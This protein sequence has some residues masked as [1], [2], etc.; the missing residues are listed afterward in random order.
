MN[1]DQ[2]TKESVTRIDAE[3][4]AARTTST[5]GLAELQLLWSATERERM[6]VEFDAAGCVVRANANFLSLM[7][8]GMTEIRGEHDRMFCDEAYAASGAYISL[9][10]NLSAGKPQAGEY[11]RLARGGREVWIHGSY[12]PILDNSGAL[13]KVIKTATDITAQKHYADDA[14]GKLRA[15]ERS[16][17]RVEFDLRGNVLDA[18]ENFLALL[19]YTLDEIR[20]QHHRMFCEP[21]YASTSEYQSFWDKL[22]RGEYDSGQYKRIGKG[23][24]EIWIQAAYNPVIST[25]GRLLKIVKFAA[26]IS[27]ERR[28]A[29]DNQGRLNAIDRANGI[30]EFDLEGNVLTANQNF[31]DATGYTL[32]EIV[33]KHHKIFCQPEFVASAEYRDFWSKLGRGEFY[34]GRYL[35]LSKHGY[36]VW[37]QASYN[38]IFDSNGKPFK[39]IKFAMDISTEVERERRIQSHLLAMS[40]KINELSLSITG[41]AQS[42]RQATEVAN[43]TQQEAESG[44]NTLGQSIEAIRAIEKSSAGINEIVKVIS[45]IANQ[46]NMLAFNAAIEAARAGEHGLGFSVVAS[47]V[48]KLAERS[49]QATREISKL[50]DE[51]VQRV[52]LGSRTSA[53]ASDG[54]ERIRAGVER[55]T[56][57]IGAIHEVTQQQA[58]ATHAVA[59]LLHELTLVT[60]G[61]VA[62]KHGSAGMTVVTADAA[63]SA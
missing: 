13:V 57:T 45:D 23:G 17:A 27:G 6:V 41:I 29:A 3:A 25:D 61:D 24:R 26:D 18:N 40:E 2:S 15:M 9:W 35:R 1:A 53:R 42:T 59:H 52:D 43:E 4:A 30:V 20:G 7:G 38:P 39:V 37:L 51:S 34:S 47:E 54:F 44:G 28:F 48:R 8:Y 49:S 11:R 32:R 33:G 16:Q 60:G 31:L 22:G 36:P 58:Q 12:L 10:A 14:A 55:T 21:G 63:R 5:L 56:R 46:T 50:I 62:R 19:G